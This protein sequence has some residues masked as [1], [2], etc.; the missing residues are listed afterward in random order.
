M[1]IVGRFF[2]GLGSRP[3]RPIDRG[4]NWDSAPAHAAGGQVHSRHPVFGDVYARYRPVGR[5]S[6]VIERLGQSTAPANQRAIAR[7]AQSSRTNR[8]APSRTS[9]SSYLRRP[10]TRRSTTTIGSWWREKPMVG[11]SRPSSIAARRRQRHQCVVAHP[12]YP[13]F[14]L[15]CAVPKHFFLASSRI[16]YGFARLV[17]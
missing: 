8:T 3:L 1:K 6:Q 13:R 14:L 11:D 2:F 10:A 17:P 7:R 5:Q 12:L 15:R 16:P 4:T 9:R